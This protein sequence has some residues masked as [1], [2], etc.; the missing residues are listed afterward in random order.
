MPIGLTSGF[1][2]NTI[3]CTGESLHKFAEHTTPCRQ[4]CIRMSKIAII[5]QPDQGVLIDVSGCATLSEALEH[6]SSTLQVSSQFWKGMKVSLNLGKLDLTSNEMN[7]ILALAKGVGIQPAGVYTTSDITR[8]SL[9]KSNI[10]LGAGKPMALPTMSVDV[11][12]QHAAEFDEPDK[13]KAASA[14][15]TIKMR[16]ADAMAS[17]RTPKGQDDMESGNALEEMAPVDDMEIAAGGKDA[18]G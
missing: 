6:L 14:I 10:P 5:S 7:Q 12:G 11:G 3:V 1:R 16:V 17:R 13:K 9:R 2:D 15:A 4:R 18:G 8:E